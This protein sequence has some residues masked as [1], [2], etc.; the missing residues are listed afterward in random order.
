MREEKE[1]GSALL[2]SS[3]ILSMLES[4]CDRY[5]VLHEGSVIAAGNAEDVIRAAGTDPKGRVEAA[6]YRLVGGGEP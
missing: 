4:Y 6:F 3:H 1:A 5:I 2:V